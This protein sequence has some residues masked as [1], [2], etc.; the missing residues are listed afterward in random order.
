MYRD[1]LQADQKQKNEA[2]KK[3]QTTP[4]KTQTSIDMAFE[5]AKQLHTHFNEQSTTVFL[6]SAA[7]QMLWLFAEKSSATLNTHPS[8]IRVSRLCRSSWE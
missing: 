5:K 1:Y 3:A 4:G 7:S 6:A 2:A 8:P